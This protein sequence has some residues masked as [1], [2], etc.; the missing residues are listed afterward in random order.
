MKANADFMVQHLA[1]YGYEYVV[2]D[3]GW[4]VLGPPTSC[5]GDLFM[6]EYGRLIPTAD[7]YPSSKDGQ[8]FRALTDYIHGRGLKFGIHVMRGI[9]KV[10]VVKNT[11]I[12]GTNFTAKDAADETV[13]CSW[14]VL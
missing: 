1:M 12:Y 3:Y 5:S 11:P 8:G 10:A 9:P 13:R 6:D 2:V 14:Y 4:F 7:R